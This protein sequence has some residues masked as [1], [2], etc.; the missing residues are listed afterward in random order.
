MAPFW[1]DLEDTSFLHSLFGI[2]A[3]MLEVI[4]AAMLSFSKD[5]D[6]GI[7]SPLLSPLWSHAKG[8]QTKRKP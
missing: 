1:M 2:V 3:L 6:E 4:Q 7:Q 5:E 8:H